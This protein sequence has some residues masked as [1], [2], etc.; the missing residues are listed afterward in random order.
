[1]K[2]A[3]IYI[4]VILAILG[5]GV[6]FMMLNENAKENETFKIGDE[7][8][9]QDAKLCPDG[10]SVGRHGEKCEF[11]FCEGEEKEL[12]QFFESR[13][14]G[15]KLKYPINWTVSGQTDNETG[16]KEVYI[17]NK[18]S[19][20]KI[21]LYENKEKV[22]LKSWFDSHF[23]KEENKDCE[24]SDSNIGIGEYYTKRIRPGADSEEGI[25]KEAGL[26][27][28]VD[29]NLMIVRAEIEEGNNDDVVRKILG[30]FEY[31]SK[32]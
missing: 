12:S 26:Y 11:P 18:D 25:C 20:L 1:M 5:I 17:K 2:K 21:S 31:I 3:L 23:S 9:P 19:L 8:C 14:L 7:H 16:K 15:V 30:S 6:W 29:G 22:F 28:N 13:S 4:V 27:S 10:S 32:K 24:F